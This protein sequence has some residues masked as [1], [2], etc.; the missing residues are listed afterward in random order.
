MKAIDMTKVD[1]NYKGKWVALESA[2]KI[3]VVA[4]G[5]NLKEVL[6]QAEQKGFRMP[7]MIQVPKEIL[8]IVGTY[9]V[10]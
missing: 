3:K 9:A 4:S 1:G 8:P 10:K 2:T 7:M 5:K 6:G